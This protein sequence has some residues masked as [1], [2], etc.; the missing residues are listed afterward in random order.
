MV[1]GPWIL[2][3]VLVFYPVK[4]HPVS[5]CSCVQMVPA[6]GTPPPPSTRPT[7]PPVCAMCPPGGPAV[8][9]PSEYTAELSILLQAERYNLR[10]CHCTQGSQSFT[11][12]PYPT[13]PHKSLGSYQVFS[14]FSYDVSKRPFCPRS[15]S[16]HP[17]PYLLPGPH[18]HSCI[19]FPSHEQVTIDQNPMGTC[20]AEEGPSSLI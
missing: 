15:E 10:I 7:F 12:L 5:S 19:N 18:L 3:V 2:T 20:T 9:T 1:L 14:G 8:S 4:Q 17:C 13:C 16:L 6:P 11:D